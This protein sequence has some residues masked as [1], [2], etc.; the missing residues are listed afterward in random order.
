MRSE[1]QNLENLILQ[2]QNENTTLIS[3][4]EALTNLRTQ[5]ETELSELRSQKLDG[6]INKER[7]NEEIFDQSRKNNNEEEN[8]QEREFVENKYKENSELE[9]E[10]ENLKTH[11]TDLKKELSE[12]RKELASIT[13]LKRNEQEQTDRKSVV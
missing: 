10:N 6:I 9:S 8:L 5:Y 13:L 3:T 11:I 4:V 2:F 7:D 12:L 1:K